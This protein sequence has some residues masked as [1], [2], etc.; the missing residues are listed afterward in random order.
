MP[1]FL[2]PPSSPG[3]EVCGEA[4]AALAKDLDGQ[5]AADARLC[6]RF[7][8]LRRRALGHVQAA[9]AEPIGLGLWQVRRRSDPELLLRHFRSR[10]TVCQSGAAA[11]M[12]AI[13]RT[14]TATDPTDSLGCKTLQSA[15]ATA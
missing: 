1:A 5:L 11:R 13:A 6:W 7:A 14:A 9:A 10:R 3:S 12:A 8:A 15:G 4:L 2:P